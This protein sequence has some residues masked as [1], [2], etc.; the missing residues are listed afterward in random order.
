[1]KFLIEKILGYKFKKRKP[2][3][4][5]IIDDSY[6]TAIVIQ[7]VLERIQVDSVIF[8]NERMA[9]NYINKNRTEY[10]F[11]LILDIKLQQMNGF[12]IGK[13]LRD[14]YSMSLPILYISAD[15]KN[16][17]KYWSIGDIVNTYF[18]SKPFNARELNFVVSKLSSKLGN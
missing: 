10:S 6:E 15:E 11:I 4:I 17:K 8:C 14:K 5:V 13:F 2:K 1:M 12:S 16:R 7:K 18:L 3:Q 9:L